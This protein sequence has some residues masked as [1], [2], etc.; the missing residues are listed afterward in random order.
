MCP[1][2]IA[3]WWVYFLNGAAGLI[4]LHL[5]CIDGKQARRTKSSSPLGQLFDHGQLRTPPAEMWMIVLHIE[6][7][8]TIVTFRIMW[9]RLRCSLRALGSH[10]HRNVHRCGLHKMDCAG[11]DV[12]HGTLAAGA[13]GGIPLRHHALWQWLLGGHRGQLSHGPAPLLHCCCG[14]RWTS[15][16]AGAPCSFQWSPLPL[17][18]H[19]AC[20]C[21][22][23]SRAVMYFSA[24]IYCAS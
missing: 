3:P 12:H 11:C 1:A 2:E 22:C 14:P 8:S 19:H 7:S 23:C 20:Q 16:L 9:C 4:Y 15:S 10:I 17:Q 24:G 18:R 13:L 5:D 6:L 21:Y